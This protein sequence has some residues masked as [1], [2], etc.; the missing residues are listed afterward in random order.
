MISAN[1]G[2]GHTAGVTDTELRELDDMY[3]AH[4]TMNPFVGL[5]DVDLDAAFD[6]ATAGTLVLN[7]P[8]DGYVNLFA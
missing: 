8:K 4:E 5:D 7:G 2:H 3:T 1:Y 6:E